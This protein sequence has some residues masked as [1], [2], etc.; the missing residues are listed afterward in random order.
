VQ[1]G[2]K[3]SS[4]DRVMRGWMKALLWVVL[5]LAALFLVLYAVYLFAPEGPTSNFVYDGF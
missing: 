5:A 2:S 1:N 3:D 4:K